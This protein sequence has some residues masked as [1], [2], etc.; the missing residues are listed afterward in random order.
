MSDE[1]T[2]ISPP[3]PKRFDRYVQ[4]LA[5]YP[6]AARRLHE[7]LGIPLAYLEITFPPLF[8]DEEIPILQ[9][10]KARRECTEAHKDMGGTNIEGDEGILYRTMRTA[11]DNFPMYWVET[12]KRQFY[13][14]NAFLE[15]L[16]EDTGILKKIF[17]RKGTKQLNH[18]LSKY[19][20]TT[21]IT[22]PRMDLFP[23]GDIGHSI[24]R[25]IA[26]YGKGIIINPQ[27]QTVRYLRDCWD[28]PCVENLAEK[29]GYSCPDEDL[30][31]SGSTS[32]ESLDDDSEPDF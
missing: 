2:I 19:M 9:K 1:P 7:L 21:K 27:N 32:L 3:R 8:P 22:I 11:C 25:V 4:T 18:R 24:E 31:W 14:R 20:P 17:K 23:E 30:D 16:V 28:E 12:S 10:I 13:E 29:M 6:G 15:H 5:E 26:P